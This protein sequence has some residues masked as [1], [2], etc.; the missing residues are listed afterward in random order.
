MRLLTWNINGVK[1]LPKY[2]PWNTL[3]SFD[4]ILQ[5]L[6]ADIICFQAVSSSR[7]TQ[8]TPPSFDAFISLPVKKTGYSGVAT[9]TKSSVVVPLKAE[10]GLT[11][12]LQPKLPLSEEERISKPGAYPPRLLD[13]DA[14]GAEGEDELDFDDLD[15]EGRTLVLD[16]GLF[17]L[18]NTYS[19]NVGDTP[20]RLAYKMAYHKL[21]SVRVKGLI[22]K[23]R[24][25]V[26]VVGDVNACAAVIDHCEGDLMVRKGREEG[27]EGEAGF[28]GEEYRRWLKDWVK[29]DGGTM[30]DVVR[31]FWPGRKGMYTCWNTKINARETNYGTRIDYVLCTPG[32]L[33]WI[34]AGDTLP[35]IKGSD[36][37]PVFV[38]FH[39]KITNPDGSVTKL[40]DA[41]GMGPRDEVEEPK[42]R[43]PPR[44]CARFWD[45]FSGKQ[46]SLA[47]FFGG[48]KGKVSSSTALSST[49]TPPSTVTSTPTPTPASATSTPT[50]SHV[51]MAQSDPPSITTPNTV[52]ASTTAAKRKFVPEP[53]N[54]T[55][56]A[57]VKEKKSK[58]GQPSI[59]SFFAK[60]S[61]SAS[62][63]KSKQA[64]EPS[65]PQGH[66]NSAVDREMDVDGHDREDEDH[67]LAL[68][69][70]QE[71]SPQF[72]LSSSQSSVA[73]SSNGSGDGKRKDK[74]KDAWTSL[75]APTQPPTCRV[76][77]EPAKE[78]TV[79]KPGPNKGKKFFICS[80]PVGPG[81]D[82]GKSERLREHVDPQYRCDFFKWSSDV[83]R[84]Q[85]QGKG[86]LNE[87]P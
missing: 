87:K 17:V 82:K 71:Y 11:G 10:E 76:H 81:Y 57:K 74:A 86:A 65:S 8:A 9:Y 61:A 24:R 20:A 38:D 49:P 29:E 27:M 54:S 36:H 68:Q 22:E 3:A 33:P 56:K 16:F 63:S 80:R 59:A 19:P 12:L 44:L 45:E 58:A 25:Q 83:R 78:Y 30:V 79:N 32:L 15:S 51:T 46:T 39:D 69:L 47:Q 31:K 70:S 4:E 14:E 85:G 7:R 26:I 73:S 52:L 75:L 6:E 48:G 18:I 34:K 1:T 13:D 53:A 66:S 5:K 28:W 72:N 77:N 50:E 23:E 2:H 37:C 41:L 43:D 60:P 42:E 55:K 21:L 84:E 40:R 62:T 64:G 35:S 67:K